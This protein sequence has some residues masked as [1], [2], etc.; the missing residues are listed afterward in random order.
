MQLAELYIESC[1]AVAE[2]RLN[3]EIGIHT[4]QYQ[5]LLL[6]AISRDRRRDAQ[7]YGQMGHVEEVYGRQQYYGAAYSKFPIFI[8][9]VP[10]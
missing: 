2:S 10:Y 6:D 7:S 3:D 9:G 4:S 1:L 5:A 8:N